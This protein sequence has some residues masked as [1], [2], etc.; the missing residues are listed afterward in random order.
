M[1]S[2]TAW[3]G[4][5]R[6]MP[7]YSQDC[8]WV[9]NTKK[10]WCQAL[11][12]FSLLSGLCIKTITL[13]EGDLKIKVKC[14]QEGHDMKHPPQCLGKNDPGPPLLCCATSEKRLLYTTQANPCLL[15]IWDKSLLS[16]TGPCS[17]LAQIDLKVVWLLLE[18]SSEVS[19]IC[20][21]F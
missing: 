9:V 12:S 15:V 11:Y 4:L 19:L 13:G 8:L 2:S 3:K 17:L 14:V 18:R 16:P 21:S 20:C 1:W 5:G 7:K 6:N 10:F